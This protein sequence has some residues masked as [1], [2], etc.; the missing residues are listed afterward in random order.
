M[1]VINKTYRLKHYNPLFQLTIE[2]GIGDIKLIQ[3]PPFG[4]NYG[5]NKSYSNWLDDG[6]KGLVISYPFYMSHSISHKSS[7]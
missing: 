6:A 7:F 4:Y 1:C 2:K 3:T 5:K